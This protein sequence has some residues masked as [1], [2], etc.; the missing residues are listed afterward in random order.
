MDIQNLSI[1][2]GLSSPLSSRFWG[3]TPPQRRKWPA[4]D[5]PGQGVAGVAGSE[6]WGPL[7]WIRGLPGK[8][9]QGPRH[10]STLSP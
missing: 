9:P 7:L 10:P 5:T 3:A 2:V 6:G 1:L 8:G 4:Q